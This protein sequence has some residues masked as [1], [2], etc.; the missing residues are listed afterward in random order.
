MHIISI[1]RTTAEE[2]IF[3]KQS[4]ESYWTL[5]GLLNILTV[6]YVY[7]RRE[8]VFSYLFQ[9]NFILKAFIVFS[10]K[11]THLF[12][13]S[14]NF[15]DALKYRVRQRFSYNHT[16]LKSQQNL[17]SPDE[18]KSFP[19][20]NWHKTWH[21]K[22]AIYSFKFNN[23]NTRSMCKIYRH[24]KNIPWL[25]SGIFVVNFEHIR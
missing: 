19:E 5:A 12:E 21:S 8:N 1:K 17:F 7:I 3:Y 24:N 15:N 10:T 4:Y 23:E 22:A 6:G 18:T 11:R 25:R 13:T 14:P 9:K 20:N 2:I 16:T